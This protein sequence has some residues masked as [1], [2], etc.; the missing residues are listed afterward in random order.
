MKQNFTK[1]V[2]CALASFLT[3]I[4]PISF[5]VMLSAGAIGATYI[6]S[7]PVFAATNKPVVGVGIRACKRP[8][9]TSSRTRN[10]ISD[11]NNRFS[12]SGLEPGN[13]DVTLE[14]GALHK[15]IVQR[16]GI[17]N[18]VII[19]ASGELHAVQLSTRQ[20]ISL[21]EH[22]NPIQTN[23]NVNSK[24]YCGGDTSYPQQWKCF[25]GKKKCEDWTGRGTGSACNIFE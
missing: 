18:G 19:N 12:F 5:S 10:T 20:E 24:K 15:F 2:K 22:A 9:G 11:A 16:D 7:K 8:G 25:T 17:L 23:P 6:I 13:Y 21:F 14:N 3:I 4:S 1:R